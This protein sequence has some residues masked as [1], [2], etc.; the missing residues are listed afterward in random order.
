MTYKLPSDEEVSEAIKRS[1][2]RRG[3]VNSQR[4]LTDLVKRELK[5][6]DSEY[7]VTEER[8]RKLAIERGLA[9]LAINARDTG[10]KTSSSTCPVCSKRM[11][12]IKNLTVYGGSVD[13]GYR[14][15]KCGYWT[16]VKSRRP[17]RYIFSVKD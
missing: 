5:S 6:I 17:I 16:G 9:K 12:H 8:V 7:A 3:L 4:K 13:L 10:T 14:C 11:G 2:S 1:L 15:P